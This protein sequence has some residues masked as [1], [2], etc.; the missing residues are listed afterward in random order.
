MVTFFMSTG[1]FLDVLHKISGAFREPSLVVPFLRIS[2]LVSLLPSPSS[3]FDYSSCISL[4]P[5]SSSSASNSMSS[6]TSAKSNSNHLSCFQC[7][8]AVSAVDRFCRPATR[9]SITGT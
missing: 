9:D 4:S 1:V 2:L 6:S 7:R 5:P 3:S 8:K